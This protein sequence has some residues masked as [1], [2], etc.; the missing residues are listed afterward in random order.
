MKKVKDMNS[1]VIAKDKKGD[2]FVFT[3]DEWDYGEG[4]RYPEFEC[5]TDIQEAIDNIESY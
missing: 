4:F 3:Q 2:H 1:F 5:G